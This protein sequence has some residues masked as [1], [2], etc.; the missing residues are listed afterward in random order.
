MNKEELKEQLMIMLDLLDS[1]ETVDND[2]YELKQQAFK[3]NY[4][5]LKKVL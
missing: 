1:F 2:L 5:L 4:R 3:I